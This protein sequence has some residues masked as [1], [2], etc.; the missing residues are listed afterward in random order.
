M[1]FF[2]RIVLALSALILASPVYAGEF[3][4]TSKDIAEGQMIHETQVFQGFGCTGKNVSPQLKWTNPPKG[5]K[6]F[7][8]TAYDPD[9]PTGSG[10]WHWVVYNIP[11]DVSEFVGNASAGGLLPKGAVEARTDY[12]TSGFGGP[13]PPQGAMHRYEFTVY[14]LGV[15]K[16]DL[17]PN[18]SPALIGFMTRANALASTRIT[19]VYAR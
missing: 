9:A 5:T 4:L 14:A 12:G 17:G 10:W 2:R 18:A 16:L 3:K 19:S 6:S 13:C 8:V 7:V 11:S 15:E 1:T